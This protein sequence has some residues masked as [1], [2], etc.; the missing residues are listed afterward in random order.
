MAKAYSEAYK[1]DPSKHKQ[2]VSGNY[3][4]VNSYME[5]DRAMME[6]AIRAGAM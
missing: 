4:A 3:I 5:R 1:C 2:Y 6:K